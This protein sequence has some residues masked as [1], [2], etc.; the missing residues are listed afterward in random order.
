MKELF[1]ILFISF[2]S[3]FLFGCATSD[4]FYNI[5]KYSSEINTISHI[6]DSTFVLIGDTQRTSFIEQYFF[7]RESNDSVQFVLFDSI[8]KLERKPAFIL[9]LGDMVFDGSSEN[10]WKYFDASTEQIRKAKIPIFPIL[11]NHEFY[12]D[13][14]ET[15]YNINNRFSR[16]KDSSWNTFEFKSIGIILLNSNEE[17]TLSENERQKEFYEY[18][19]NKYEIDSSIKFIIVATHHPPYTNGTGIGFNESEYTQ[20]CFIN[21]FISSEKKG[22]FFSGHFHN[23]EHLIISDKHFIVSGGGGGPRRD[24]DLEGKYKDISNGI[25]KNEERR[26]YHFIEI[27]V[28]SDSLFIEVHSYNNDS[29]KWYRGD[30]FNLT[31]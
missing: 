9:H 2:L 1:K 28:Q 11:G 19:M 7:F 31:Y 12:G 4:E 23:Y 14:L 27:E 26:G 22:L 10:D 20:D 15:A 5:P 13:S 8:A 29:K 3:N 30:E 21:K 17:L 16:L 18:H 25:D 24:V 6:N